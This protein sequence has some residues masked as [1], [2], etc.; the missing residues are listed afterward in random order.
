MSF[1]GDMLGAGQGSDFTAIGTGTAGDAESAQNPTSQTQIDNSYHDANSSMLD[2]Q[3]LL[4]ALQAQNGITNQSQTYNQMQGIATGQGP[5]PAQDQYQQ[6]VQN[7]AKQQAGAISS[8]KGISPALQARLIAQQGSGAMQNAAGQ[9][10]ANLA[11]QQLGALTAAGQ[12]A[13]TQASNYV[14]QTNANVGAQQGEQQN[15]LGAQAAYNNMKAGILSNVNTTNS[16]TQIQNSKAQQGIF[17]GLLG[18]AGSILAEGGEVSNYADGGGTEQQPNVFQPNANTA[19]PGVTSSFGKFLKGLS[20]G[21]NQ[22]NGQQQPGGGVEENPMQTG[23]SNFVGKVLKRVFGKSDPVQDA[24]MDPSMAG[25]DYEGSSNTNFQTGSSIDPNNMPVDMGEG[26]PYA[27]SAPPVAE[28]AD[29]AAGAAE[30][31]EAADAG[32]SVADL[33]FA[34]N[35]GRINVGSKLKSGGKVPGK[36]KFRG[37]NY[38]NDVVSAKLSPGEVVIPNSVMQSGDPVRG[39]AQ[40]VQAVLARKRAR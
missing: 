18:G 3:R 35:G 16:A 11:T 8:T 2:Q 40:F 17:G 19:S 26:I 24:A 15:L 22:G 25:A 37:N 39:A 33:A 20:T 6:N 34:A 29:A 14:G 30:G 38:A 13:N 31:A 36:P 1:V 4:A 28:G 21:V 7:L 23:T 32:S 12:M 9:G 27:P 5:N 10:Q